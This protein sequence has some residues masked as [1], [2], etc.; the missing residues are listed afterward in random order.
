MLSKE[1][2]ENSSSYDPPQTDLERTLAD[3]WAQATG[4][5]RVGRHDN[6]FAIGGNSLIAIQTLNTLRRLC[7]TPLSLRSIFDSPTV[8]ELAALAGAATD[9]QEKEEGVL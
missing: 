6:F 4:K 9:N 7:N 5:A 1:D 3:A 2:N 8:A